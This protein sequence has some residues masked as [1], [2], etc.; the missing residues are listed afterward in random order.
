MTLAVTGAPDSHTV[1]FF[2]Q[3][4]MVRGDPTAL[5][6]FFLFFVGFRTDFVTSV[7]V[8]PVSDGVLA[9]AG[10]RPRGPRKPQVGRTP[11]TPPP[12]WLRPCWCAQ[13]WTIWL[14]TRLDRW[15]RLVCWRCWCA[16]VIAGLVRG[17]ATASSA[18]TAGGGSG[19]HMPPGS[20]HTGRPRGSIRRQCQVREKIV[21]VIP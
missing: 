3:A 7:G 19:G 18:D 4:Q 8:L 5:T 17:T 20:S 13:I 9:L 16:A 12:P 14:P 11:S 21:S 1:L 15:L 2:W 6:F 10:L